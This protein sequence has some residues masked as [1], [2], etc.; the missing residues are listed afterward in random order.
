MQAETKLLARSLQSS[1]RIKYRTAPSDFL[2]FVIVNSATGV[3][4]G[5]LFIATVLMSDA[6]GIATLISA[7]TTSLLSATLFIAK[8]IALCVGIVLL[9]AML[10]ANT[11]ARGYRFHGKDSD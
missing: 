7:S 5:S 6:G 1:E 9:V 3:V 2:R 8:G 11:R 4:I 10:A